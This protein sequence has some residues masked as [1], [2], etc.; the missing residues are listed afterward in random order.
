[1]PFLLLAAG[2]QAQVPTIG[3]I[4][5]YG[6]HRVP[7]DKLQ[8]ALGVKVGDP[9]P[10][11]KGD[12]EE[13]LEQVPGVVRARLEA[14]CCEEGK[15]ILYVGI[16][17][18]GERAF[19][20]HPE[21]VEE[22]VLPEDVQNA[23]AEFL[24]ALAQSEDSSEDLRQGHPIANDIITSVK[25]QRFIGLAELHLAT[26]RDVLRKAA[27]PEQRA[28]AATIL[29]YAPARLKS[30]VVPDLQYAVQD[31]DPA[32]R[33]N[34]MRALTAIAV[35]GQQDRKLGIRVS[36]TW[37]IELLNSLHW[38]DRYQASLS[39]SILTDSRDEETLQQIRTRALRSL[40]DMAGWQN[41]KHA[42]PAYMVLGR[43]TGFDEKQILEH[44]AKG[45]RDVVIE[46]A[47]TMM[48]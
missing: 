34:A 48:R 41:Y 15:A 45:E 16:E 3:V 4:D 27:D 20:F 44:W 8:K 22:M 43:V 10:R 5:F 11:S 25:Q 47:K 30:A 36:P 46:R 35:L 42:L 18:R 19:E 9:L 14:Q 6:V 28:A 31:P 1:M 23:Y 21:P 37:F 17:E 33:H 12:V 39:L 7:K 40:I 29:G 2:L 38:R 13:A 26:L 32:V 24:D